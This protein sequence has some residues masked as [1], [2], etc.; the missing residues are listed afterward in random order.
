[1][2]T[3]LKGDEVVLILHEE[4]LGDSSHSVVGEKHIYKR[5]VI[6]L[7]R[8]LT[9]GSNAIN[10]CCGSCDLPP[11]RLVTDSTY[12]GKVSQNRRSSL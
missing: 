11:T 9:K 12:P 4:V 10:I 2:Y 1:M 6:E 5:S 8:L 3:G 7:P